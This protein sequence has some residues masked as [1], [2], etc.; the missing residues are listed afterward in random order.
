[1]FWAHVESNGVISPIQHHN[2][3]Y[4]SAWKP[5]LFFSGSPANGLTDM[6]CYFRFGCNVFWRKLT[7]CAAA[8]AVRSG[9][10]N[11][12]ETGVESVARHV[13]S[14]TVT[15]VQMCYGV[16]ICGSRDRGVRCIIHRM[17]NFTGLSTIRWSVQIGASVWMVFRDGMI[18]VWRRMHL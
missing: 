18:R 14:E 7:C 10:E 11:F 3:C 17:L 4:R 1:M 2:G 9:T 5:F 8:R 15:T 12:C 16:R 13:W 6:P